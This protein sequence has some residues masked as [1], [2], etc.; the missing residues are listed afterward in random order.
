MKYWKTI[1][2]ENTIY[3]FWS[4][5][6]KEKDEIYVQSFNAELKTANKLK[7]V[8][9]IKTEKG[10]DKQAET[11][12][13]G[14]IK[15]GEQIVIGGE[16]S[17]DKGGKIVF[18][19]KVL[20]KNF[21]FVAS[22]QLT[23]PITLESKTSTLTSSYRLG[24]D[25][26][27]HI[28]S[29]VID[30]VS[31]DAS[32]DTGKD[33]KDK[34]EKKKLLNKKVFKKY[35]IYSLVDLKSGKVQTF[36]MNYKNKNIMD[37]D[38]IETKDAIKLFGFF[39]DETKDENGRDIHGIFHAVIN[40]QTF[41]PTSEFTFTYFTKKE[42]DNLFK[43]D[44]SDRKD[45]KLISS[46][47]KKASEELSIPSNYVI[48]QV[49]SIDKE[50]TVLFCSIMINTSHQVCT[51]DQNGRTTCRT[52]YDCIKENLTVF[53]LNSA[54]KIV[55]ASN[56]D[57]YKMYS[58]AGWY[59]YDVEVINKG[60]KFIA[61]YG[62]AYDETAESED[63]KKKEEYKK[64]Y[65]RMEYGVFDDKTGSFEKKN[66]IINSPDVKGKDKHY[67]NSRTVYTLDNTFYTSSKLG[68]LDVVPLPG[69]LKMC[70]CIV[71]PVIPKQPTYLAKFDVVK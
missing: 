47:K 27:L 22:D 53:K 9:E 13:L 10:A 17:A 18:Q 48:E 24:D 26:N 37:F 31:D 30:D 16:L 58:G 5:D 54:G 38:F 29:Y 70:G 66:F 55:W 15:A 52:V 45:K 12:V 63:G 71:M 42:L 25:G 44:M 1:V 36:S 14:N 59:I 8:Y 21:A 34:K 43:E 61:V 69:C 64:N 56:L 4:K 3:V 60:G 41:K 65:D 7:K 20:D 19:Y 11:L 23:L 62:S 57:R 32:E 39:S 6:S 68:K 46:K 49:Q 28:K 51:T 35:A 33:K 50:H 40:P 2:L 67:F